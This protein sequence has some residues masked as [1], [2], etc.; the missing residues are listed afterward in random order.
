MSPGG[1][2]ICQLIEDIPQELAVIS[3]GEQSPLWGSG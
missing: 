2:E 1:R 3:L